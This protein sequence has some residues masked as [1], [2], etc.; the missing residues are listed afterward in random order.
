MAKSKGVSSDVA[1]VIH[2]LL[3]EALETG[4]RQQLMS[5]EINPAFLGKVIDWLKHNNI[6]VS[7]ES[8][9]HLQRLAKAFSDADV[10]FL[11]DLGPREI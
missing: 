10:E 2:Q 11:S 3:G 9:V 1:A 4:L 6:T 7:E 5:G 8:D